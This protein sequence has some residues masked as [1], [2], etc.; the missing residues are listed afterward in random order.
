MWRLLVVT[1]FVL[2][3]TALA[4][5]RPPN[6]PLGTY[7]TNAAPSLRI[8]VVAPTLAIVQWNEN[9]TPKQC[10][11]RFE[12]GC[13]VLDEPLATRA[14]QAGVVLA[15]VEATP[16][17]CAASFEGRLAFRVELKRRTW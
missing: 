1:V 15:D 2:R 12:E 3:A 4:I 8:S 17:G 5:A 14:R 13:Y 16:D 7:I 10:E 6:V 9:E 11:A